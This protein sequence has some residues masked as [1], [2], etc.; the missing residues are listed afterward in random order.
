MEGHG[1]LL[2]SAILCPEPEI[3]WVPFALRQARRIVKRYGIQAVMVT[4]P[5]FSALLVGYAALKPA[6]FHT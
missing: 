5:P 1:R 4:V 6:S 3:L 2:A